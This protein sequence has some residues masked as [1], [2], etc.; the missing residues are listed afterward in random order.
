VATQ[1]DPLPATGN[2]F[3]DSLTAPGRAKLSALLVEKK[4]AHAEV[5][6][7][8]GE[9]FKAVY[10][11][12]R[13]VI[14]TVTV[15]VEGAAVEVGLAGNEGLSPLPVAFGSRRSR[16]GTVVQIPDSALCM[17][18]DEFLAAVKD[19]Q[20][21]R[22]R[23]SR[24]A[25]YTFAAASQFAACNGV[26]PVEE[27]YARW[28]LMAH[29]RVGL[30]EFSLTQEYSA[31]MLGVRRA[32]VTN[33]ALGLSKTGLITYRRGRIVITDRDGLEDAAC[34]CY[35]AVNGD[36]WRLMGYGFNRKPDVAA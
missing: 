19:D 2:M 13:S 6:S 16:H 34:E 35:A 31:Q 20:E 25:E 28:I 27:R 21:L 12:I 23:C 24:L 26:H 10:F 1:S 33:I 14:S 15:T 30:P 11:P 22:E 8:P 32:T 3:L 5:L 29:D 18:A 36:L 7:E 9:L 17:G 4:V